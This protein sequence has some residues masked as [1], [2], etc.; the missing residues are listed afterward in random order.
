MIIYD[1]FYMMMRYH[2][3]TVMLRGISGPYGRTCVRDTYKENL[4]HSTEAIV[5]MLVW[6]EW[7]GCHHDSSP[8]ADIPGLTLVWAPYMI[9][10]GFHNI[11]NLYVLCFQIY[12]Y[13]KSNTGGL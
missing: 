8:M 5:E 7:L 12:M 13:Y 10:F 9:F 2:E 3:D 6:K 11:T 4:I 1:D